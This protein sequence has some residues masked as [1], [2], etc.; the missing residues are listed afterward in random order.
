MTIQWT[1]ALATDI[2]DIDHQHQELFGRINDLLQACNQG[3]GRAEVGKTISFLE[4]YV[5]TH[6]SAEEKIMLAHR[7]PGYV[8]H[9]AEHVRFTA[10]LKD[11]KRQ[12]ID[13]GP[14]IHIIILTNHIVID[15][16]INH[17]R[18]RDKA[19]GAYMRTGV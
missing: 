2:E 6:F 1:E 19:F 11:L 10:N 18:T 3:K 17:I 13:D 14:G 16:L 8:A 5:G 7:F 4:D 15:W 9:K 12:M